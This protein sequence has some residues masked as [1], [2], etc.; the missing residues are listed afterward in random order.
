MAVFER[1][2]DGLP[3]AARSYDDI[4]APV[5]SGTSEPSVR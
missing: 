3:A 1:G 5:E 2:P 4:E